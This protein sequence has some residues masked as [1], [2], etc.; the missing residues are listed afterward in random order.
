MKIFS[1]YFILSVDSPR[2]VWEPGGRENGEEIEL[3]IRERK[4]ER[5]ESGGMFVDM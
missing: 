4:K 5:E 1:P 3:L 2:R